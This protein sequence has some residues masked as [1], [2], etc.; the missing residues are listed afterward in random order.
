MQVKTVAGRCDRQ[1]AITFYQRQAEALEHL[2]ALRLC[3][4]HANDFDSARHAQCDGCSGGQINL[5]IVHRAAGCV[6]RA[7]NVDDELGDALNVLHRL[8]RVYAAFKTVTRIG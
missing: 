6:W 1:D 2:H 8:A 3:Q 4:G 7:A 5:C